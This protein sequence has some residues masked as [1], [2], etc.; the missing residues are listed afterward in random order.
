[1]N[2]LKLIINAEVKII[3][4]KYFYFPQKVCCYSCP[5]TFSGHFKLYSNNAFIPQP[6]DPLERE[7]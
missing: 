6:L 7:K 4:A 5:H 2:S 1:M 3:V